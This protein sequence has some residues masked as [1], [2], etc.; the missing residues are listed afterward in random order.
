MGEP[1]HIDR[2]CGKLA[3]S[4]TCLAKSDDSVYRAYGLQDG[5]LREF[6]SVDVLKAGF[7]AFKQ[8]HVGGKPVGNPRMLPGTFIV[9]T[10]ARIRYTYY[11]QHA[12]DHPDI[13]HLLDT[14]RQ[15]EQIR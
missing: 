4:L 14:A 3:P 8:G 11:S 10:S 12:G 7:R 13:D 9:D 6:A 1:K 2:Y 5:G 15:L